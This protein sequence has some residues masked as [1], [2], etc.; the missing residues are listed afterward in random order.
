MLTAK[1]KEYEAVTKKLED[2]T[3]NLE[4][5]ESEVKNTLTKNETYVETDFSD[6]FIL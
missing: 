2:T 5:K 1:Q 3:K 6:M 4:E